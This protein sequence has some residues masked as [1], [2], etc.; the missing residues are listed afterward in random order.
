[1]TKTNTRIIRLTVATTSLL[2]IITM[3][4]PWVDEYFALRRDMSEFNEL[5]LELKEIHSQGRRLV[6]IEEMLNE[7]LTTLN[8][9]S[10]HPD[11]AEE[12]R[13]KL[14]E[15]V[16]H[17]GGRLRSLELTPSTV[18]PWALEGDH[19]H[20]DTMP[21][22]AVESDYMLQQHDVEL[23]ADGTLEST[24]GILRELIDQG[25]F[26]STRSLVITPTGNTE[27]PVS[28]EIRMTLY[29]LVLRPEE[30]EEFAFRFPR[31]R[32]GLRNPTYI[33]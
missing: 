15:I 27:A 12:V 13:E 33:R 32:R 9:Q 2:A 24:E 28:I 3:G 5:Q 20:E 22:F 19:P 10:I 16:R 29:G 7:E 30:P 4:I 23:R 1:M 18:R 26:M 25:W 14:N 21:E 8:R 11:A 6:K 17:Q 31:D